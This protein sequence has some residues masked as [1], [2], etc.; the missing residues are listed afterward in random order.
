MDAKILFNTTIGMIYLTA[1]NDLPS[2]RQIIENTQSQLD[3]I[4]GV[5]TVH[6]R[7]YQLSSRYYQ[8]SLHIFSL[9]EYFVIDKPQRS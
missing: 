1:L 5:T 3:E 7:F 9:L 6:S 2:A 8:V 4:E